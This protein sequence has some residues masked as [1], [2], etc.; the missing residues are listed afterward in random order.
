MPLHDWTD[1]RAVTGKPPLAIAQ[2]ILDGRIPAPRQR[3]VWTHAEFKR[4]VE[5]LR[6]N[7]Q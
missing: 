2:A 1:A 4:L 6:G 5:K 7:E 3:L